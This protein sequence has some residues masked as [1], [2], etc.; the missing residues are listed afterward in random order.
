MKSKLS[1]K[2]SIKSE[3]VVLQTSNKKLLNPPNVKS[4][5]A[6]QQ[7]SNAEQTF[8]SSEHEQFQ[9]C[10]AIRLIQLFLSAYSFVNY[11]LTSNI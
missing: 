10:H 4:E 5:L 6:V 8:E 9:H 11:T 7:T 1:S 2:A 3:L